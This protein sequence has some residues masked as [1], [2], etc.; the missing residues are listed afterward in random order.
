[1]GREVG[2]KVLQVVPSYYPA[3]VYGGPI[4]SIHQ[5]CQALAQ[6]GV[7]IDVATTNAN[8]STKLKVSTREPV[9]FAPNYRVRYYDD[10][11]IGRFSWAFTFNLWRD[12]KA[13]EVV[14]LQ[15]VFSAH[16]AETLL[17]AAVLGKPVLVSV[18]G[19]FT[20]WA[21]TQKRPWLKK[22]WIVLLVR[23]FVRNPRRVA[24]HATSKAERGE[25]LAQFPG[26]SVQVVPN[27]IDCSEFDTALV[28][29]RFDYFEKFFPDAAVAPEHARVMIGLGRLHA[30]KAFDVAI[31]AFHTI[32]EAHPKA[33]L[34]IAGGDDGERARLSKLIAD[35]GLV[36]RVALV[37]EVKGDDKIAFLKGADL[38]LFPSHSENFGM[39]A[40]EAMAAGVPVVA[41]RKTPWQE[42]EV[43][44]SGV[45]VDNT[46]EAFARAM[47]DLMTR[48]LGPMCNSA[49][50]HAACYNLAVVASAF[51]KVYSEIIHGKPNG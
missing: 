51:E 50:A 23:P 2:V 19:T 26:V 17:F 4:F 41:S 1:M 9:V 16:A 12:I 35:L 21:L 47:A 39:V 34:L 30:I 29:L 6:A 37:G 18:R 28:P 3:T 5:A 27:G 11:I 8:G 10:T 38:L 48:D 33:V 43:R 45:W 22:A 14:H 40:L 32:A 31:R 24:W 49:R 36:G 25:I 46:P 15:D 7:T 20:S 44:G 13:A 42:V